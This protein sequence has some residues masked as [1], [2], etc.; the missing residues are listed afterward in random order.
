MLWIIAII[1]VLNLL[2]MERLRVAILN[3]DDRDQTRDGTMYRIERSTPKLVDDLQRSS[4][5]SMAALEDRLCRLTEKIA[6]LQADV[7]TVE[8]SILESISHNEERLME[9][10]DTLENVAL[11]VQPTFIP[12]PTDA[13]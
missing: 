11:H 1:C 2:A 9:L 7:S 10:Q 5:K 3:M 8:R 6:D 12:V 4:E 13:K